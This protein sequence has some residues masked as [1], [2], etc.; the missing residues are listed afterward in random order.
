MS[1]CAPGD[2]PI[3]K[4]YCKCIYSKLEKNYSDDF[5]KL[6]THDWNNEETKNWIQDCISN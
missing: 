1:N 2:D 5:Q 4:E 3:T 6:V